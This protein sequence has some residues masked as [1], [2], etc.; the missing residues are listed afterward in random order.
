MSLSDIN[1][2]GDISS[3]IPVFCKLLLKLSSGTATQVHDCKGG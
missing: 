1:G 3:A 2:E